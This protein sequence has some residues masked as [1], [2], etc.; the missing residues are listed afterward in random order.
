[1]NPSTRNLHRVT[2]PEYMDDGTPKVRIPSHVLL[3]GVE[4][5]KEYV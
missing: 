5:Q 2:I 1:M 4:N 3:G